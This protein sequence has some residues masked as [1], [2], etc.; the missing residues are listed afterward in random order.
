MRLLF[1]IVCACTL[2]APPAAA[3][4]KISPDKRHLVKKDGTPFFWLGDTAWELF[5]RLTREEATEYLHNRAEKGFTVIQ[6]VALAE[7]D[8]LD[9]PN[10]YGDKPL[11]NNDPLQPN[12]A[13]FRHV[14]FIIDE[15]N[16]QG[17]IMALLPS[18]GDKWFKD[19]WGA[20][21][22]IFTPANARAYGAWIAKRY[23]DKD[24]IYVLGGD[25]APRDEKD[26]AIIRAM[27]EGIR[28][29]DG[30]RHLLTFHPNGFA[31]SLIPAAIACI[32]GCA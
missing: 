5:H 15:A 18:W 13:Y 3:Q 31:A 8:G 27:A 23:L 30:G 22:E 4:L 10:V 9:T 14:D 32:P 6:A 16:K 21:P 20:G 17:L 12:E 25:R 26:K 1:F 29:V 28:S 19:K 7:L 11:I 24:I 2:A